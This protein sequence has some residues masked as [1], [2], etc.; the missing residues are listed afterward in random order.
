M[1][2]SEEGELVAEPTSKTRS[3]T[4]GALLLAMDA[5]G[6]WF[7]DASWLACGG[8]PRRIVY[9]GNEERLSRAASR[10]GVEQLTR[11]LET[12]LDVRRAVEGNANIALETDALMLRRLTR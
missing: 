9:Q 2:L 1:D 10:L 12:V 4:R 11:M 5:L 8:D 7:H 3:S 6:T